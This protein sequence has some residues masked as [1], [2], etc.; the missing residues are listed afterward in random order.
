MNARAVVSVVVVGIVAGFV[1]IVVG[2]SGVAV[3]I[4][5]GVFG[6]FPFVVGIVVGFVE[7]LP[8]FVAATA[9][10][11]Q[12]PAPSPS[13]LSASVA[14]HMCPAKASKLFRERAVIVA[15]VFVKTGVAF[16]V[17]DVVAVASPCRCLLLARSHP[18]SMAVNDAALILLSCMPVW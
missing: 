15:P 5:I 10:L 8:L 16:F 12:V 7:L 4:V 11:L 14:V 1:V 17:E 2:V 18:K 6:V 3:G 9:A 13:S